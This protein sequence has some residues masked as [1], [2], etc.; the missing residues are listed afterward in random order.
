MKP[1]KLQILIA[2]S[3]PDVLI[4][5]ER[6]LQDEG[7]ETCTAWTTT[8]ALELAAD[9]RFDVLLVSDHPPE[10]NCEYV[11][12][13]LG[14]SDRK[15]ACFVLENRPRHP[16]AEPWLLNLGAVGIIHKWQHR[17]LLNTL[18]EFFAAAPPVHA[19]RAVAGALKVG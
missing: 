8:Q 5:L 15:I 12:R 2:D 16:F 4:A 17:E 11:L 9:P 6:V 18:R 3:D 1:T 19:K 7:Y 13:S 14:T 10:I